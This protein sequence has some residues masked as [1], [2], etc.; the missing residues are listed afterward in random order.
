[1]LMTYHAPVHRP[2]ELRRRENLSIREMCTVGVKYFL[3]GEGVNLPD[4]DAPQDGKSNETSQRIERQRL[5]R[6][7]TARVREFTHWCID[8][9]IGI[10][11]FLRIGGLI[12]GLLF[13]E[14]VLRRRFIAFFDSII[15]EG[16]LFGFGRDGGYL[17][18]RDSRLDDRIFR[19]HRHL[20]VLLY[21]LK[22]TRG[23]VEDYET[24]VG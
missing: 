8:E 5:L 17:H 12:G 14:I 20:E 13:L 19:C 16:N 1:M 18:C 23:F 22:G 21:L 2:R 11:L 9:G 4:R 10:A 7:D 6:K 24:T 15:F 3:L